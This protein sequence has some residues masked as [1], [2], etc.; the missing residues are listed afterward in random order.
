MMYAVHTT[1]YIIGTNQKVNV[2][3]VQHLQQSHTATV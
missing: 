1:A 3:G 2:S